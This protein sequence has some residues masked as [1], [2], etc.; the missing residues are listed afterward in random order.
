MTALEALQ[1]IYGKG[2]IKVVPKNWT[3]RYDIKYTYLNHAADGNCSLENR[4]NLVS[5]HLAL[6]VF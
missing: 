6:V 1:H 3:G 4:L 5:G 2:N